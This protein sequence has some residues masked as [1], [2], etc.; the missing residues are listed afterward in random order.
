MQEEYTGTLLE[1]GHISIPK[2]IVEKLKITSGSRLHVTVV[3][4]AKEIS[5]EKILSYAGL[6]SDLTEQE[7]RRFDEDTERRNL[8]GKRKAEI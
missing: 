7:Q 2:E 3:K 1:D 6:L 5:K 4:V 8:F